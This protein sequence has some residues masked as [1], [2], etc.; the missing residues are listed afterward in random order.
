M[1]FDLTRVSG[2]RVDQVDELQ[3]AGRHWIRSTTVF[4][5]LGGALVGAVLGQCV[6]TFV[7]GGYIPYFLVPITAVAA[8]VLFSRKRSIAG[9]VGRRRIEKIIDAKRVPEGKFVLPGTAP[10]S[11]NDFELMEMH[12][13]PYAP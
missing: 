2:Q 6:H 3:L 7:G 4:I 10:F 1:L 9:E 8:V 5:F 11:V 12:D 13:H